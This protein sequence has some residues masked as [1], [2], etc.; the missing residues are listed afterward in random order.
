MLLLPRCF[1]QLANL[2]DG[3]GLDAYFWLFGDGDLPEWVVVTEPPVDAKFED[4]M[5]QGDGFAL[6]AGCV[7]AVDDDFVALFACEFADGVIPDVGVFLDDA[8]GVLPDFDDG[9]VAFVDFVSDVLLYCAEEGECLLFSLVLFGTVL[10]DASA[11]DHGFRFAEL[12][13]L[14]AFFAGL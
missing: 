10:D 9:A 3:E 12:F 6:C 8:V 7:E 4:A 5:Q 14:L 2:F 11:I 13:K 1:N